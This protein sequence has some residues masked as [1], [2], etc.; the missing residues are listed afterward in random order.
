MPNTNDAISAGG[1]L[2][3]PQG[4]D[5]LQ[6]LTG[7][8]VTLTSS[9]MGK[10]QL[11][12][13]TTIGRRLILPNA[14]TLSGKKRHV[15]ITS[16]VNNAP[17]GVFNAGTAGTEPTLEKV[18]GAGAAGRLSAHS[19]SDAKGTW[20]FH[21]EGPLPGYPFGMGDPVKKAAASAAPSGNNGYARPQVVFLSSTLAVTVWLDS[22][23]NPHLYAI[24]LNADR[25]VQAISNPTQMRSG[26]TCNVPWVAKLSATKVL[27]GWWNGTDS[28]NE[29]AAVTIT[30]GN[31]PTI[32]TPGSIVD[33]SAI[34]A[35]NRLGS[36]TSLIPSAIQDTTDAVW[37]SGRMRVT[38]GLIVY[39]ITVSGT[40]VTLA[41]SNATFNTNAPDQLTN[42]AGYVPEAGKLLIA[43]RSS[44][45][46]SELSLLTY[47]AGSITETWSAP[48]ETVSGYGSATGLTVVPVDASSGIYALVSSS[49]GGTITMIKVD[50]ATGDVKWQRSHY[51][52]GFG[53]AAGVFGS[54]NYPYALIS[55]GD[56]ELASIRVAG[57][58]YGYM[59]LKAC[60]RAGTQSG[61]PSDSD[62]P[63]YQYAWDQDQMI[64][65]VSFPGSYGAFDE[66]TRTLLM[67]TTAQVLSGTVNIV[68]RTYCIPRR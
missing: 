64:P 55:L 34:T 47:S 66:T 5:T 8:N 32:G 36:T 51:L 56:G 39:Y 14:T 68:A 10:L 1:G 41:A 59:D 42:V 19:V 12:R 9:D 23:A 38:T 54:T 17:I 48:V 27:V 20:G 45:N 46:L 60:V 2:T 65:T 3:S 63:F 37:V 53:A 22:S 40:T 35:N 7:G 16:A 62:L 57:Y 50:M 43:G 31:P 11:L 67:I 18:L 4:S 30:A 28:V 58:P 24:S 29:F 52:L 15:G 44:S 61:T 33:D 6:D 26:K 49:T 25:S 13:S 21:G